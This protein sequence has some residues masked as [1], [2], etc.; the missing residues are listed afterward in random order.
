MEGRGQNTLFKCT[1]KWFLV[2]SLTCATVTTT[3]FGTFLLS[4][5]EVPYL[6]PLLIPSLASPCQPLI[7][8]LCLWIY[9]FGMFHI[10]MNLFVTGQNHACL[11]KYLYSGGNNICL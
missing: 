4:P 10:S 2:Y 9:L 11:L 8:F 5:K 7:Y 1:I 6:F 3:N